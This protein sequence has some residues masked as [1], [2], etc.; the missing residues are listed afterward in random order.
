M[1]WKFNNESPIYLQI[2]DVI[3]LRILQGQLKAGDKIASVRELAA[4]AGVNPNTMQKALSE[5]EREG[6]LS[7]QRTSGRFVAD[8]TK[9]MSSMRNEASLKHLSA[10][11]NGMR[12]LSYTDEEILKRLEEYL[13]R[14][15]NTET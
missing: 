13:K 2:M 14:V 10:F 9:D 3:R 8:E 11:V 7:S 5:L 15:K 4:E 1:A 6:I 12:E